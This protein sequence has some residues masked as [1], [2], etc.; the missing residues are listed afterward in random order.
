MDAATLETYNKT[1][2][3]NSKYVKIKVY[4]FINK[5]F[6]DIQLDANSVVLI[7]RNINRKN[8]IV[9]DIVTITGLRKT[10]LNSICKHLL[11]VRATEKRTEIKLDK[12]VS[13]ILGLNG[14]NEKSGLRVKSFMSTYYDTNLIFR[15]NTEGKIVCAIE[16]KFIG[17]K[18]TIYMK[19]KDTALRIIDKHL[20][21]TCKSDNYPLVLNE[22][23]KAVAY[24]FRNVDDINEI[25]EE[26]KS[27]SYVI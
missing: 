24:N 3:Y 16:S 2:N 10:N 21:V 17:E 11:N 15:T 5:K 12:E 13:S 14:N 27:A 19:L 9:Y 7:K 18:I 6:E 22:H 8:E 1:Q 26:L 25:I 20:I 23:A 4:K